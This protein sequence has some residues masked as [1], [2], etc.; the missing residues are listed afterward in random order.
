MLVD[1]EYA[2]VEGTGSGFVWDKFGHIVGT[3]FLSSLLTLFLIAFCSKYMHDSSFGLL[4]IH[5]V[6]NLMT[7]LTQSEK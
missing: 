1:G 4:I 2:K 7:L 3:P 5:S 6:S